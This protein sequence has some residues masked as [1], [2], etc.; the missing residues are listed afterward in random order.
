MR[1]IAPYPERSAALLPVLRVLQEESG[2]ISPEAEVWVAAELGIRPIQV[3]EVLSFYTMFRLKP[4]LFSDDLLAVNVKS[5]Q[6]VADVS[7]KSRLVDI[8]RADT[9]RVEHRMCQQAS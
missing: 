7:E 1:V 4:A 8:A 9:R 5:V 6:G 3:R 2:W